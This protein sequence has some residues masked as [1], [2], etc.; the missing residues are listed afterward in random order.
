MDNPT[1]WVVIGRFGRPHGIKGYITVLS[2]TEPRENMLHY[3]DW[4]VC[5]KEQWLPLKI[6]STEVNNKFILVQVDGYAEREQVACLTNSDI[7]VK[8]AQLPT[9]SPGEYYWHQLVGMQVVTQQ[10]KLLGNVTEVMATG[11]NDV[12][13]VLGER[14][15][16]VPYI[17]DDCVISIN[18]AQRLI[19]VNW[20]P[21]F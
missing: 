6:L 4:N 14:R 3:T 19:T 11:A 16:L 21:D 15:H 7:A 8:R 18:D 5:I 9:L 20:D 17:L 10:G 13:V 12:L 1:D 2:F